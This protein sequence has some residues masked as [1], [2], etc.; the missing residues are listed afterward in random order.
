MEEKIIDLVY[1]SG[2]E[3]QIVYSTFYAKSL[4]RIRKLDMNAELGIL[5]RKASDCLYKLKGGCGANAIHP[6]WQ[7]LDLPLEDV[8]DYAVRAW[9]SGHLYPGRPTGTRLDLS[10]LEQRGITD[11]FLNEPEVYL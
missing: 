5:D 6:Y 2:Y 7:D 11:I 3:K 4:Q 1:L 8:K 10:A 9:L